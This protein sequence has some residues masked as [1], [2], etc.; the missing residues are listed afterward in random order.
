MSKKLLFG[1][2]TALILLGVLI[3]LVFN[4]QKKELLKKADIE[5]QDALQDGQD[6][7]RERP[8]QSPMGVGIPTETGAIPVFGTIQKVEGNTLTIKINSYGPS[9][10]QISDVRL[11]SIDSN[12]KMTLSV[13]KNREQFQK[14]MQEFQLKM[15]QQQEKKETNQMSDLIMPP[16]PFEK[17]DIVATDLK[18]GQQILVIANE[19]IEGKKEFVAVRLDVQEDLTFGMPPVAKPVQAQLPK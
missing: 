11:I 13:Q 10:G 3:V 5:N 6:A 8:S 7:N 4:I 9:V 1:I 19:D 15:A 12:T 18:E 2:I 14:E 17:R 16:T